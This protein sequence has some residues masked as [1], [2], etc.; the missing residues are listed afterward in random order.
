MKTV[1]TSADLRKLVL[2]LLAV[3]RGGVV[4]A[5][6]FYAHRPVSPSNTAAL[7]HLAV[8]LAG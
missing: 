5:M 2:S 6:Y 1:L 4:T 8:T 7:A 3:A